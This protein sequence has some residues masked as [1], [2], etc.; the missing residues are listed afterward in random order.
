MEKRLLEKETKAL[1][2]N[3]ASDPSQASKLYKLM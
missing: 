1:I 2:R 3:G